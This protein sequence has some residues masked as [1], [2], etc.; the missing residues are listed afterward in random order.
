MTYIFRKIRVREEMEC[1][2]KS[3]TALT[4]L[5]GWPCELDHDWTAQHPRRPRKGEGR[6]RSPQQRREGPGWGQCAPIRNWKH[7]GGND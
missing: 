5:T 3:L 4:T 7:G 1:S 6:V 2:A